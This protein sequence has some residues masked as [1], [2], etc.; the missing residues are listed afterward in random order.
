MRTRYRIDDFQEC[1]FVLDALDDLLQLAH[2]DFAP[3]YER[4]Q[5][6]SEI[7]PGQLPPADRLITRGSGHHHTAHCAGAKHAV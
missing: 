3:L 4:A 2:I 6:Q 5:C 7:E 1:Y